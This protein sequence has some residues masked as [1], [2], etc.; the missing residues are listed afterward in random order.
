MSSPPRV[1]EALFRRD[2]LG[3]TFGNLAAGVTAVLLF[4]K[5]AM[6]WVLPTWVPMIEASEVA[7]GRTRSS[8]L[9]G[10]LIT[11]AAYWGIGT[12]LALPALLHVKQW[13][14][15]L[16]RSLDRRALLKAMPLIVFNFVVGSLLAS[17][18]LLALLPERSFDW[19][20]LPG[21]WT[22]ARDAVVW[23]L[24]Q[25][26]LFFYVHRWLHENKTLYAAIHKKHHT[27]TSPVS[28]TAGYCHPVE[29][30]IS[31]IAPMV[32]G[33]ILCGSHI[34]AVGVFVFLF[35]QRHRAQGYQTRKRQSESIFAGAA[36]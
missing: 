21:T 29:N 23:I 30:L 27:W 13:K 6:E 19:R 31:N 10:L 25:E 24:V 14:I 35:V 34:A 11:T 12:L 17:L 16:N 36:P 22:L 7:M 33:P 5:L 26:V 2:M 4:E 8:L 1:C 28:L 9:S 20:R 3:P 32:A 15:Q 18:A